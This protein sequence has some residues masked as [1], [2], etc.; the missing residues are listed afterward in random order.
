MILFLLIFR[1]ISIHDYFRPNMEK[2]TYLLGFILKSS[3]SKDA[4]LNVESRLL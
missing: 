1:D 4:F 3:S 2:W